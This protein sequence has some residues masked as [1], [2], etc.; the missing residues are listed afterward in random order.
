MVNQERE[1]RKQLILFCIRKGIGGDQYETLRKA[2]FL[3]R[4]PLSF[5]EW[6][7]VYNLIQDVDKENL[8]EI[9]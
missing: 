2:S 1:S 6:E 8:D 9:E 3:G 7:I 5:E 4:P